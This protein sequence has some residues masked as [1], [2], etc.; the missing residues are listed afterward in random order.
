[1]RLLVLAACALA[2]SAAPVQGQD[3]HSHKGFWISFGLGGGVNVS[4]GID[5]EQLWGGSGYLRLGGTPH[6][7]WL[8]GGEVIGWGRSVDGEQLGRG[9]ATFTVQFYPNRRAEFFVKGGI[10][11]T[12]LT[13]T[14]TSGNT[15]TITSEQGFGTTLGVGYD[16]RLGSNFFLTPN[17]DWV[18]QVFDAETLPSTNSI[19][20]L[21]IGATWH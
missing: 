4:D 5:G 20:L 1:M 2:L 8:L 21:T 9:N 6:P 19:I 17:L 11:G 7:Q 13:I 15:T 12:S 18:L 10:G 16:I 3:D 14:S